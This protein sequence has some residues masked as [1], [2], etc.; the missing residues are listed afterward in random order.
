MNH[1]HS[2]HKIVRV[3]FVS[4]LAQRVRGINIRVLWFLGHR[5][6]AGFV[7]VGLTTGAEQP[8]CMVVLTSLWLGAVLEPYLAGITLVRCS[9]RAILSRY[10]FG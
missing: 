9:A 7:T 6:K 3:L 2:G 4:L 5:G 10:H 8:I 1:V